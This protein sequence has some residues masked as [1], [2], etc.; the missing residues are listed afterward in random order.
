MKAAR[1]YLALACVLAVF[2]GL[3]LSVHPS[4]RAGGDALARAEASVAALAQRPHACGTPEHDAALAWLL[5]EVRALGLEPEVQ[6]AFATAD[7]WLDEPPPEPEGEPDADAPRAVPLAN[8]LVRVPGRAGEGAVLIQAH[9]DS[10]PETPGAG[11]DAAGVAAVLGALRALL[12]GAPYRNDLLFHFD[13]GEELGLLGARLFLERHPAAADV[14]CVVNFDARGNAGTPL[15]FEVG[16]GSAALIDAFAASHPRPVGTSL[17]AAVYARMRNDTSFSPFRDAG[18]P[19]L[20]FA[21]VGGATAY[22]RPWDTPEN[23]SRGTL[24]RTGEY[25]LAAARAAADLDLQQLGQ[26]E[27]VF[28]NAGT[29]GLATYPL[30][31]SLPFT[32][33]ALLALLLHAWR[34]RR[35][36]ARLARGLVRAAALLLVVLTAALTAWWVAEGAARLATAAGWVAPEPRGNLASTLLSSLG[37]FSCATAIALLALGR[38]AAR[39]AEADEL[40]AGGLLLWGLLL[41][42]AQ[43]SLPAGAYAFSWPLLLMLPG[44][45]ARLGRERAGA[46]PAALAVLGYAAACSILAPTFS[47]LVQ[48]GSIHPPRGALFAAALSALFALLF[49]PALRLCLPSAGRGTAA[50]AGGLGA[51]ALGAGSWLAAVGL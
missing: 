37:V 33:L 51:L 49:Q 21:F 43:A 30:G 6:R 41:A 26:G 24:A 7:G 13:D 38:S 14:R 17:A 2:A 45:A 32:V 34:A 50:L 46:V 12:P 35:G 9:Y 10:R 36:G 23:L 31:W 40:A 47:L 44:A 42:L 11:D 5:G 16:E 4:A 25:A 1:A 20:N 48:V 28:F 18:L 22:H 39:P 15:C 29:G 3:V 19:G 27:R 8:V